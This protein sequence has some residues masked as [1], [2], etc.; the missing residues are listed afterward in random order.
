MSIYEQGLKGLNEWFMS[1]R[2]KDVQQGEFF[3]GW[4]SICNEH[5]LL[6]EVQCLTKKYVGD[7]QEFRQAFSNAMMDWDM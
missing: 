4:V 1:H 5:N 2:P 7:G 3:D 6:Y